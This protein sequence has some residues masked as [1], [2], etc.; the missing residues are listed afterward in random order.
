MEISAL[1]HR[2]DSEMAYLKTADV[3]QIRLRTKHDDVR[4]VELLYGDPYGNK[5][6]EKDEGSWEYETVRMDRTFET[7]YH[8]YWEAEVTMPLK[9]LQYAFHIT[10][11]DGSEV[12]YD[13]RRVMDCSDDDIDRLSCFRMPYL[14]EI[15]RVKTPEWV[16]NTVWYQIFPERF[17]NG[18]RSN[19]P[20]GT[21]PWGGAEPSPTNFFGGD[22]QGVINHL[23]YLQE[24]GVNGLYFCPIFTATSNHKYD[25]VDYFG[26][27]PSFGD[28]ETLKELVDAAHERGMHVMLDAVFNHMGDF[29]MQWKDVQKYGEKSRFA[30]WFHINSFPVSYDE[31]ENAEHAENLTYEVFA[32]TPHMPKIDTANEEAAEYLL[33][34]AEYWIREFDIDAW[35]LDVANEV[36]HHFWKRFYA[37]T[38]ALKKDFYVV[39][40]VWHSAQEWLDQE[41]FDAVMNYPFTESIALDFVKHETTAGEMVSMLSEQL[42][43]YRDQTNGVMLNAMDTHDT[44]R[45]LTLCDGN[46]NLQRQTLAFMFTQPGTPCIYYGTE[47]GLDGGNDPGCRKC[48]IWDEDRQDHE[49]FAFMQKLIAL[50]KEYAGV[51]S[52]GRISYRNVCDDTNS[53]EVVRTLDGTE[54]H[55]F[56]NLGEGELD[57]PCKGEVLLS[58]NVSDGKVKKD[59]FVI[60][61]A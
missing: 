4:S 13:D 34:I 44:A 56:F 47:V 6:N 46:K 21:L 35:R 18:D 7:K 23:D 31:S 53:L 29:S 19:D 55:A 39:G 15:D 12:L 61:K 1:Y 28:K 43:K 51:W 32:T 37:A 26:I 45:L 25:T 42:M 8:D 11:N 22:L 54:L 49:M 14:H 16:R 40:E 2:P 9:R 30:K 3:F 17:A 20:E 38:H 52:R 58:Q 59:G 57:A 24:L 41:E 60:T 33:E 10:G 48:M 5:V 36:D 50:R 27:D